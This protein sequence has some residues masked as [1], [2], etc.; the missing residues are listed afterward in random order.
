MNK[1]E[2]RLLIARKIKEKMFL[3]DSWDNVRKIDISVDDFNGAITWEELRDTV[4][5]LGFKQKKEIIYE[6][7]D[8][9]EHD[10]RK[11][12]PRAEQSPISEYWENNPFHKP[13]VH[14]DFTDNS[15]ERFFDDPNYLNTIIRSWS[16]GVNEKYFLEYLK[17]LT[18]LLPE[19]TPSYKLEPIK[20]KKKSSKL[21]KSHQKIYDEVRQTV[22]IISY[23][24]L[25][26]ILW[27][28]SRYVNTEKRKKIE[29]YKNTS[30]DGMMSINRLIKAEF[31]DTYRRFLERFYERL[32]EV[33]PLDIEKVLKKLPDVD[34][35]LKK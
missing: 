34:Q 33:S 32:K 17:E 25:Y 29:A 1:L 14:I 12:Y 5:N 3:D 6:L 20:K 7:K 26:E 16:F 8:E 18:S 9:Y 11:K 24:R 22:G 10:I 30:Q 13:D 19:P 21:T 4:F 2:K 31:G 23:E 28:K 35:F 15:K 27:M